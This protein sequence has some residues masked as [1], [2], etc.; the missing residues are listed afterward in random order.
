M[1][2]MI[3]REINMLEEL[4]KIRLVNLNIMKDLISISNQLRCDT[5]AFLWSFL[6][7][8]PSEEIEVPPTIQSLS[9]LRH[10]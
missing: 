7:F 6:R 5:I 3:K 4:L 8:R 1:L 2:Q 10:L 9:D